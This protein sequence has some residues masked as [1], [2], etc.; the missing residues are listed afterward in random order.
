MLIKYKEINHCGAPVRKSIIVVH[1]I[2]V[3]EMFASRI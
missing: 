3:I 2:D 1:W